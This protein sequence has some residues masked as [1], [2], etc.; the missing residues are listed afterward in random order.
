MLQSTF[1]KLPLKVQEF[2]K[3]TQVP[4]SAI[5]T[6]DF[7]YV[8]TPRIYF[9]K[10]YGMKTKSREKECTR[11]SLRDADRIRLWWLN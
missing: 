7:D 2:I 6:N 3:A 5:M 1:N 11:F 4:L 10:P 9:T 8:P